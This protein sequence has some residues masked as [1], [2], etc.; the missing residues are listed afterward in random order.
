MLNGIDVS[1]HQPANI[2]QSVRADVVIVKTTGGVGYVSRSAGQQLAD[3]RNQGALTG[4]YHFA[5]DGGAW[6]SAATEAQHFLNNSKAA[7]DLGAVPVL[8]FEADG[9]AYGLDW[10]DEWMD[11]VSQATGVASLFYSYQNYVETTARYHRIA[12][13]YPLWVASY[14]S[15]PVRSGFSQPSPPVT[16]EQWPAGVI[17]FQYGSR[18]RLPGYSGDLDLNVFYTSREAWTAPQPTEENLMPAL[19]DKE[20]EEIHD[21]LLEL[22]FGRGPAAPHSDGSGQYPF[23]VWPALVNNYATILGMLSVPD[24]QIDVDALA[25]ALVPDL[26]AR[27]QG[28]DLQPGDSAKQI[29]DKL[30]AALAGGGG[31][32][33]EG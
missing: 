32:G 8:D 14:G 7:I 2:M 29:V 25:D 5:R 13:K 28:L 16:A 1:G 12:T 24:E 17:G 19:S 33:A 20:N 22:A 21:A 3:S 27:I 23:P 9:I 26:A 30:S 31:G 15:N 6:G 11:R 18:G 10:A 4:A